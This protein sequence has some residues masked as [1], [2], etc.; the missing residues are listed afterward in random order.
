MMSTHFLYGSESPDSKYLV[1]STAKLLE[2]ATGE[3]VRSLE[4]FPSRVDDMAFSPDG[5]YLLT[6]S[7]DSLARLYDTTTGQV[8]HIFTGH[9]GAVW[10]VAFSPDGTFV[11]S[12]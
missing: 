5:T 3:V 1:S 4:A 12:A 2:V 11:L 9:K 10:H 8:V 6:G 7:D